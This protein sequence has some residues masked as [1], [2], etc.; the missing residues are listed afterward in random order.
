[1]KVLLTLLTVLI[2]TLGICQLPD[3]HY[4]SSKAFYF[5]EA[6]LLEYNEESKEYDLIKTRSTNAMIFYINDNFRNLGVVKE[7]GSSVGKG[8]IFYDKTIRIEDVQFDK[9]LTKVGENEYNAYF[10]AEH[11]HIFMYMFDYADE[12]ECYTKSIVYSF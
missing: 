1:M 4:T 12:C 3:V 6:N 2:T 9:Y 8:V 7:S 10:L 11:K 5:S